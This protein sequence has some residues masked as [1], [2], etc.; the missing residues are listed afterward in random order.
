MMKHNRLPNESIGFWLA[1]H[2]QL[3]PR[4]AGI[5]YWTSATECERWSF[6]ELDVA[7]RRVAGWLRAHGVRRGDRVAFHDLNDVRFPITMFAAAYVGAI[8]VP[9]NFRLAAPE[10]VQTLQDCQARVVVHGRAFEPVL[11]VLRQALPDVLTLLSDRESPGAFDAILEDAAGEEHGP[12]DLSWDETAFL[13][14]TSGSTGRP[15]GVR[16]SHGN[17]FWNTIN[18]ILI[19]GGMP[20][21]RMLISAPLFHAAPVSS[22]LDAFLRGALI[23]LE[24]SFQSER[25]LF[26]I[27]AEKINIVAGVPAMYAMMAA[28]PQFASADLASLRGIIVGGSPVAEALIETYRQ[29]GVTVIQRYGLTEAAPLVTGLAPGSP[30]SK[31]ATA[32]LPGMF[33]EMRIARPDA[34]GIGEIQARGA[35][36]MQGYWMREEDT[37]AAFED[38][39]LRTGD[40]GRVDAEGYLSVVGRCKD[41]IISGGEN[42]YAAEV[43]A[44]L[45]EA[46]GVLEAAVIGVPHV[47]W[48]ETVWAMVA[49]KTGAQITSENVLDHLQGRLARYKHPTRVIILD[50]LPKNGAGKVDKRALRDRFQSQAA[51]AA[52]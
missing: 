49:P 20:D 28:D 46:P 17:L 47:K 16:L 39:W 41:M 14:Y 19:Q 13:L 23:H 43:E 52:G 15:K 22:F 29:R 26:R 2:A 21:D 25:V 37:R 27:A 6:A 40:L 24:R 44:R 7:A 51:A 3:T 34:E 45:A 35:N 32:G 30:R 4:R 50:E 48:G 10:L 18:T 38:G 12:A 11:A 31:A 1:R 36:V 33:L 9:L 42:I 5:V 8:F